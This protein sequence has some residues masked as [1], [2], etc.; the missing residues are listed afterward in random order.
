MSIPTIKKDP[1]I[2]SQ[3]PELEQICS[4]DLTNRVRTLES[5]LSTISS[6]PDDSDVPSTPKKIRF[7]LIAKSDRARSCPPDLQIQRAR[8]IRSPYEKCP[9]TPRRSLPDAVREKALHRPIVKNLIDL[10]DQIQKILADHKAGI[11]MRP[12][13]LDLGLS[14][15]KIIEEIRPLEGGDIGKFAQVYLCTVKDVGLYVLKFC[16]DEIL[17]HT[18]NEVLPILANQLMRYVILRKNPILSP[19]VV[20][21]ENFEP[22]IDKIDTEPK[23]NL[24]YRTKSYIKKNLSLGF[25]FS[26]FVPAPFPLDFDE[27]DSRWIQ[28]K[29][30]FANTAQSEIRHDFT[31]DNIKVAETGKLQIIDLLEIDGEGD[32][33]GFSFYIPRLLRTFTENPEK[34][35]WVWSAITQ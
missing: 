8:G 19:Y 34:Q 20:R 24:Y 23:E 3:T 30:I 18:P 35:A 22:H 15:V 33:E 1:S 6:V 21:Y 14:Q 7:T 4:S 9:P 5:S 32:E 10:R 12:W 13:P 11:K 29:E 31:R 27:K 16:K 25:H 28:L 26:P 2:R 17:D